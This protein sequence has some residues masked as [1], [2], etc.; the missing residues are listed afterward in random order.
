MRAFIDFDGV[1]F[2]IARHKREYFRFFE[3]YGISRIEARREYEKM[4]KEI[5]RDDQKHY[6]SRLKEKHPR[7]RSEKILRAIHV[8]KG[9]SAPCVYK[10]ARPFLMKLK[11]IDFELHLVTSGN[12]KFQKRKCETSGLMKFFDRIHIL[13]NDNKGVFIRGLAS[14]REIVVFL[15]DKQSVVDDVKKHIPRAIILQVARHKSDIRS[16]RADKV[17]RN[18][19]EA[20]RCI[21]TRIEK[22]SRHSGIP[23]AAGE[24]RK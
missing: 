3:R 6:I 21:K 18:L 19:R 4:K 17:V 23:L 2:D 10:E 16:R 8:F 15:D 1:L 12:K 9:K 20:L 14:P 7:L 13:E 24:N 11:R 22:I 5:G